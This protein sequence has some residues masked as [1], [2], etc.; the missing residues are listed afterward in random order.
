MTAPSTPVDCSP[1]RL[2][3]VYFAALAKF[4]ALTG[5]EDPR[6]IPDHAAVGSRANDDAFQA[7]WRHVA[8]T[9]PTATSGDCLTDINDGP[10]CVLE[11]TA[12]N[13]PEPRNHPWRESK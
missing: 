5:V 1:A 4:N 10:N 6:E 12:N 9:F 2:E 3:A 11:W 13:V 8:D 7:F